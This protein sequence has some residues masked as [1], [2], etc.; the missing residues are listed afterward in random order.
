MSHDVGRI[1]RSRLML[2]SRDVYR[3]MAYADSQLQRNG[4]ATVVLA[5]CR[6]AG[7]KILALV[8]ECGWLWQTGCV[9]SGASVFGVTICGRVDHPRTG[10]G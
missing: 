4:C 7:L 3:C 1:T 6:S 2:T 5:A 8:T 9:R 10:R